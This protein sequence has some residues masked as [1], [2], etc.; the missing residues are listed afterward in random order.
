[1]ASGTKIKWSPDYQ[2]DIDYLNQSRPLQYINDFRVG[3]YTLNGYAY[4]YVD[5]TDTLISLISNRVGTITASSIMGHIISITL[6]DTSID[7]LIPYLYNSPSTSHVYVY[8]YNS[9]STSISGAYIT[10]R[11]F[12]W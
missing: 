9:K 7:S 6:F 5:I 8:G 2:E 3:P 12:F 4:Y 1:M 11:I 10:V